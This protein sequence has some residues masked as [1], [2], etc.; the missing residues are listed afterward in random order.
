VGTQ[1]IEREPVGAA[2]A[3]ASTALSY[4]LTILPVATRE[5]VTWRVRASQIPDPVLRALASQALSKRGNMLGAALFAVLAPRGRRTEVVRALVAFQAAYNYLDTLAEQPSADPVGNGRRLHNALLFA[6]QPGVGHRDY[7][8]GYPRRDDGGL[9]NAMVEA[10]RGSLRVLPSYVL[11]A[12]P[13]HRAAV[14]IVDFQ[15]LNLGVRQGGDDG[16]E[17]WARGSTPPGSGLCWWETAAAGGSSLAV[18]AL[19]ALA[20][21]PALDPRDIGAVEDAYF[22]WISALH[23]LLD[24]I[25]DLAEDE[26]HGQRSLIGYYVS[27]HVAAARVRSLA[28]R[29]TEATD[30]LRGSSQHKA[31]LIAMTGYYLSAAGASSPRAR[32]LAEGVA[33]ATGAPARPARAL[34]RGVGLFSR[35]TAARA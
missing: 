1:T 8:S 30:M 34:S 29:A 33:D 18:H 9:L 3:L 10:C 2:G 28:G 16:L 5:L 27:P 26:R 13:V 23:S 11:V 25:V 24:S 35:H 32:V 6:L 19:V 4:C 22:P 7:Y 17:R 12:D 20:A 15:S 31:I 21:R 14:R